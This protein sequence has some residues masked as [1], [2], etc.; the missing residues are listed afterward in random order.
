MKEV[1]AIIRPE[2]LSD[3]LPA[4]RAMP[5][6]PGV[7]ISHVRGY[8]RRVPPDPDRFAFAA[9]DMTKLEIVVLADIASEVV[10]IIE[11]TAHTGR[12]GDGKIDREFGPRGPATDT[13]LP[14]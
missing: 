5:R 12:F 6:F 7:T 13:A 8:G 9:V 4:P 10:T 2:R 14:R 3:V 1:K 11:Q